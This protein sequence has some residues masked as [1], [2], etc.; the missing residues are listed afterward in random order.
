MGGYERTPEGLERLR[1]DLGALREDLLKAKAADKP[2]L[3]RKMGRLERSLASRESGVPMAP[4]KA[5]KAVSAP[6]SAEP[7][8]QL[9]PEAADK[10]AAGA[11]SVIGLILGIA[12]KKKITLTVSE[13]SK[14]NLR[15][16]VQLVA[17]DR[18]KPSQLEKYDWLILAACLGMVVL[19]N[20]EKLDS[21][22]TKSDAGSREVGERKIDPG[23]SI[24]DSQSA[25]AIS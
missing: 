1:F 2:E 4:G 7:G 23:D 25:S 21:I 3:E 24:P 17:V 22:A 8:I 14:G 9:S 11:V 16:A 15:G 6:V 5:V 20:G 10:V 18:I 13:E 12:L 19:E